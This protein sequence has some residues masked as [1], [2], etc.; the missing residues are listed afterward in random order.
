[1]AKV[2][3]YDQQIKDLVKVAKPNKITPAQIEIWDIAGL[4]KGSSKGAGLGNKFL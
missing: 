1:M 4:I 2:G 3:V